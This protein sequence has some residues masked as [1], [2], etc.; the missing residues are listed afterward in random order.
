MDSRSIA[1]LGAAVI[2]AGTIAAGTPRPRVAAAES[3][4]TAWG[5]PDLQ[6]IWSQK[7][8]YRCNACL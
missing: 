5:D 2:V 8:Q 7:Y 4:K 1:L 3:F 6:G